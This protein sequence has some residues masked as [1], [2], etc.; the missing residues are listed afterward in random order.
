MERSMSYSRRDFLRLSAAGAL[1]TLLPQR[2]F[3]DSVLRRAEFTPLRRNV[4]FFTE[5]GGAIGWLVN[6]SGVAVVDTQFADTAPIFLSGLR[7][8]TTRP[9][10]L[11]INSHHHPDHSGGNAVLGPVSTQ[12]V[13]HAR[14]VENQRAAAARSNNAAAQAFPTTTYTD[15]WSA[16]VGDETIRLKH[17]GPAHTGGDSAIFFEQANIVH[18]GDLLNNRGWPNIDAG[19][20]GSIHGW[21][22]VLDAILADHAPDTIYIFGHAEAGF[23]FSGSRDD[24]MY[25]RGYFLSVIDTAQRAL[26]AGQ[27][28]EQATSLTTLPG[29]EHFGG[30]ASRLALAVGVAYDELAARR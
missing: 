24:L 13:A 27:T 7:E 26:Q 20:G 21:V 10:D 23:P 15:S 4:G 2:S 14:S 12:F 25:Q 30:T 6:P 22:Q 17:Y 29:Y 11:L 18:L 19:A 3:A 1:G 5:R 16:Q 28:R 9:I 8:R